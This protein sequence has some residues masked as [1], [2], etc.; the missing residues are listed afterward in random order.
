MCG[1]FFSDPPLYTPPPDL[2]EFLESGSPPVYIGFGSIVVDNP[3]KLIETVIRGVT[4]AGVRAIVSKGWSELAGVQNPNVFY[5]GDCP[6]GWLFQHVA[7]VIHHGGAGT[8]ACGLLN[9]CPTA[10]VPF[11]GEYAYPK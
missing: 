11:F 9:G 4:M 7:A 3:Q 6:H 1:F 5:I 8:T 2:A 10:I